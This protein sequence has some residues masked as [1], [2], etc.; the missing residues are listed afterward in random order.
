ML[1]PCYWPGSKIEGM[2][3]PLP[4]SP[5][6][7]IHTDAESDDAP[8]NNTKAWMLLPRYGHA[9]MISG[10]RSLTATH[11]Q[12]IVD[13]TESPRAPHTQRPIFCPVHCATTSPATSSGCTT[14]TSSSP[15]SS[16]KVTPAR[17]TPRRN[18]K[19]LPMSC[20]ILASPR[21]VHR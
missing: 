10:I 21:W 8:H 20:C 16:A 17:M 14:T 4:C 1:R 5:L 19:S 15:S 18:F 2:P 11:E 6:G 12:L 13:W 7:P 3:N 9:T